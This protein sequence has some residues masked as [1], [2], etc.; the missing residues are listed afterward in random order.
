MSSS[1]AE[2]LCV[3]FLYLPTVSVCLGES[4]SIW[5]LAGGYLPYVCIVYSLLIRLLDMIIT[6]AL[7]VVD[8]DKVR[9]CILSTK[10]LVLTLHR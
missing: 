1:S 9:M 10:E 3:V 7:C 5:I 4:I 8:D 2:T 6:H